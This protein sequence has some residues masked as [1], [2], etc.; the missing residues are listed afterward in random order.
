MDSSQFAS[1]RLVGDAF[2]NVL[3]VLQ[4]YLQGGKVADLVPPT[5]V[6]LVGV[7]KRDCQADQ[8][9]VVMGKIHLTYYFLSCTV[10]SIS[11]Y[12][13]YVK[14]GS[15]MDSY[16][17]IAAEMHRY[18]SEQMIRA[19]ERARLV[20]SLPRK[21]RSLRLGAYRLTFGKVSPSVPRTAGQVRTYRSMSAFNL[22]G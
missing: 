5:D 6:S 18:R 21:A 22:E 17:S 9:V 11:Q 3:V 8:L 12:T 2:P 15:T 4:E 16:S 19:V 1:S 7:D 10:I 14:T 20:A 13:T